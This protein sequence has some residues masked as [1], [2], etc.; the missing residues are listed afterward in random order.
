M[1]KFT[2]TLIMVENMRTLLATFDEYDIE[3]EVIAENNVQIKSNLYLS[4]ACKYSMERRFK[5][6][7]FS[8]VVGSV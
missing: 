3:I 2:V 8:F 7:L 4:R 6:I 1:D 5:N